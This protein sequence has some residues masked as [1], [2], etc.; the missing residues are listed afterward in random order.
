M[1]YRTFYVNLKH[2][3]D[4]IYVNETQITTIELFRVSDCVCIKYNNEG[5]IEV[6]Y[7][8]TRTE[9]D[10]QQHEHPS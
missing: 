10:R 8:H 7:A 2:Y 9:S 3:F 4:F 1:F 6:E 5:D